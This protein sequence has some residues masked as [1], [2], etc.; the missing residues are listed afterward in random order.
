MEGDLQQLL[1]RDLMKYSENEFRDYLFERHRDTLHSVIC[2][3]REPIQWKSDDFPPIR[4]LLQ[5]QAEIRINE[6]IDALEYL[7]LRAR[8]LRLE[9]Q[10]DST[11]RIDLFG[12]S[13]DGGITIIELKKS[14]QTERQAFTEMLAYARHFCSIFAGL[15]EASIAC[16]LIA[17]M[18]SRTVRDAYA[19]ELITNGK[20]LLAL[21]PE[22]DGEEIRLHVYYPDE[23]HYRWYEN[24]LLDDRS[25]CAVSISFPLLPGWIDSDDTSEDQNI[26]LY[27]RVA[28]NTVSSAI[29]HRFEV[30]GYHSMVY[31]AQKW[32]NLAG[33]FPF[34]NTVFIVAVN[35]YASFR[36]SIDDDTVYGEG[37][38]NRYQDIQSVHDQLDEAGRRE[39]LETI[40]SSFL[41]EIIRL[42]RDEFFA[43][44]RNK[45][46]ARIETEI[47][48]PSWEAL[49]LSLLDTVTVHNLEIYP[50][51]LLREVYAAYIAHI[52]RPEVTHCMHYSD[53]FP[54]WSYQTLR[55]FLPVW[56]ILRMLGLGRS[57]DEDEAMERG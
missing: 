36:T 49:K 22:Q 45:G 35:P 3:R 56:E 54:K 47:G 21:V 32:G 53:D 14:A 28:L 29:A 13:P 26:P 27:S 1:K 46:Q 17:P 52:Y 11:T 7:T 43:C 12:T 6:I 15:T 23:T 38:A 2:G 37:P 19:Q 40:D 48:I 5:Q 33:I 24:S 9:R 34:P 20:H 10:A 18:A 50:T 31:A 4:F 41:G 42:A 57:D 25:M 44:F 30:R 8:E 16:V 55:N 51:G 39:W